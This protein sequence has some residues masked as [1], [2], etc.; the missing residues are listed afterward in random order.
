MMEA[1]EKEFLKNAKAIQQEFR[2]GLGLS[3]AQFTPIGAV[4]GQ[5]LALGLSQE[6][7]IAAA[8]LGP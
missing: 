5:G 7:G 6:A 3:E 2:E 1:G 4:L 8:A